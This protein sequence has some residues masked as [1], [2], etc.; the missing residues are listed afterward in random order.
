MKQLIESVMNYYNMEKEKMELEI[1][2][3]K[4]E[5]EEI[6]DIYE[7][8]IKIAVH[9]A[10]RIRNYN[11]YQNLSDFCRTTKDFLFFKENELKQYLTKIG[12]LVRDENNKYVPNKNNKECILV[13]GELYIDYNWLREELIF[14]RTMLYFDKDLYELKYKQFENRKETIV[15]DIANT[16]RVECKQ[17]SKEFREHKENMH[18]VE[19]KKIEKIL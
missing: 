10:T 11:G 1:E 8:K 2:K 3:L 4:K 9:N 15:N 18:Y 19:N 5:K 12:F 14:I 7:N 16:V 17:R 6:K 13:D